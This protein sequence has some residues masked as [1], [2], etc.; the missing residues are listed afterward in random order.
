M[1]RIPN[2]NQ[3][4]EKLDQAYSA[5]GNVKCNSHFGNQF[6]SYIKNEKLAYDPEIA[7]FN[8]YSRRK[9]YDHTN[10]IHKCL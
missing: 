6:G 7:L 3:V 9:T 10:F 8:T 1:V 5:G 2:T 4:A